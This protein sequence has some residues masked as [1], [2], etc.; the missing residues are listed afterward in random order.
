[1]N[2]VSYF[3]NINY[4]DFSVDKTRMFEEIYRLKSWLLMP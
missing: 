3:Q 1:M 2:N 4:V